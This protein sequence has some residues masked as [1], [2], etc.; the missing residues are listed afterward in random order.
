ME[1]YHKIMSL[2]FCSDEEYTCDDGNC[3][4]MDHRCD[5]ITQ[6]E[7]K[8]DEKNCRIISPD[9]NDN[10]FLV[11]P[12][13]PG[14]EDFY[15]E[16]SFYIQNVLLINED[17][18][19]VKMQHKVVK[20]WYNSFLTF[21]NLK[22]KVDNIINEIEKDSMWNPWIEN[23]NVENKEK[24]TQSE[25]AEILKVVPNKNFT[26]EKTPYTDI[27]NAFLFK[28]SENKIV[29]NWDWTCEY[30]CQF[31]Y[32]WYPFD[33]QNCPIMLNITSG[34]FKIRAKEVDYLGILDVGRYY[35][36]KINHC[37]KDKFGRT[38]MFIDSTIRRPTLNNLLTLFLPTGML[39]L[40]SQMSTIY[41][42]SFRDMIIE[43]NTTL[44]LVLTRL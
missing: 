34:K 9:E 18:N 31:D 37:E 27:Y 26:F 35:F 12:P 6:C 8:S 38:G 30:I 13:L 25:T 17:E 23:V 21:E 11:P 41:S 7:D 44:L 20:T 39:L 15:V 3:V 1:N 5:G 10:K 36:H 14:E 22:K 4:D 28:G 2:S 33:T 40:I 29:Q 43:V 19:S 24:C 42:Q 16:V 32:S